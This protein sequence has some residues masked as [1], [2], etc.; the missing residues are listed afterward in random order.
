[1]TNHRNRTLLNAKPPIVFCADF[2]GGIISIGI[3]AGAD[4]CRQMSS[5]IAPRNISGHR[6]HHRNVDDVWRGGSTNSYK[7]CK[8]EGEFQESQA[9]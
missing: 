6:G 9:A 7:E 4:I 2:L 3:V 5:I 1:M 8:V